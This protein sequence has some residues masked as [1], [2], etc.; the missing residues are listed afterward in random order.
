MLIQMPLLT[1]PNHP[2]E[3]HYG[4][5]YEVKIEKN[6]HP[7]SG[8]HKKDISLNPHSLS[9][10]VDYEN[11]KWTRKAKSI[12]SEYLKFVEELI[13][14]KE[15]GVRGLAYVVLPHSACAEFSYKVI[16]FVSGAGLSSGGIA[17]IIQFMKKEGYLSEDATLLASLSPAAVTTILLAPLG[18]CLATRFIVPYCR[19]FYAS[20]RAHE[21][22]KKLQEL[23]LNESMEDIEQEQ[24]EAR[25]RALQ[26]FIGGNSLENL[27]SLHNP[28]TAL[29]PF[30][31]QH[32]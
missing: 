32:S 24:L 2:S 30:L 14:T 6:D 25:K 27:A 17:G 13:K 15:A 10:S 21:I 23:G 18:Y 19:S 26:H 4:S 12:C 22:G 5:L 31:I 8:K 28:E 29:I 11:L 16:K 7:C 9:R 20:S 3:P 1:H